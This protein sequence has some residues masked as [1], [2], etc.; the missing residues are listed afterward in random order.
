M[1]RNGPQK[2]QQLLKIFSAEGLVLLDKQLRQGKEFA[3]VMKDNFRF[4]HSEINVL[5]GLIGG[6]MSPTKV[7]SLSPQAIVQGY[8][9]GKFSLR[10][11]CEEFFLYDFDSQG[12]VKLEKARLVLSLLY[13]PNE[14]EVQL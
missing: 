5:E 3:Q 8:S 6:R 7:F 13:K 2:M 1:L 14:L 9:V 10:Q 11:L 4:T 12:F